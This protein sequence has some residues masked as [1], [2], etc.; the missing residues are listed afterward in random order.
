MV[1]LKEF[2]QLKI[3]QANKTTGHSS[4]C[5]SKNWMNLYLPTSSVY[6]NMNTAHK[7]SDLHIYQA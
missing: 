2:A 7:K 6:F 3:A 5:Q 1:S 4:P